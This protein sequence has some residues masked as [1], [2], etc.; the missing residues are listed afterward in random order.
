MQS[1]FT[2]LAELNRRNLDDLSQGEHSVGGMV[3]CRAL[4]QPVVSEYLSVQREAKMAASR[5]DELHQSQPE[6][7]ADIDAWL[8]SSRRLWMERLD[9]LQAHLGQEYA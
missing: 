2:V 7:L 3:E 6:R 5:F 4:S 1:I 9:A 8:A